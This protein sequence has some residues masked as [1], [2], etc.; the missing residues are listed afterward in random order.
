MLKLILIGS[1]GLIFI[2]ALIIIIRNKPDLWFWIFLNLYFDPGGYVLEYL[3]GSLLGPLSITD[4]FITGMVICLIS[5]HT[6]WKVIIQDQFLKK[7]IFLLFLFV[8]YYFIVYG[9]VVPFFNDDFNY[10]TFLMKNRVYPYGFIILI[11][12]YVFTLR[13]IS[14]FYSS[15]LFVGT[16]CLTL[17]FITL[18]TGIELIPIWEFARNPGEEAIRISM[19]SYGIFYLLFPLS[20]IV[21]LLSRRMSL[22]FKYK[23]WLYYSGII[24]LITLLITLTKRLQIDIIGTILIITLIIS[25]IF[26]SGS[27]SSILKIIIPAMLVILI[28]Y[29]T[30]PKYGGYIVEI[31][32]DTFLLIATGRDS[33]GE[34]D[35]RV[36]GT[37]DY[38]LVKEYISNNL[39]FG[40]GY[41]NLIWTG[42]GTRTTPRGDTFA[43]VMD[44]AGEV[45]IYFMFFSFGITGA[46]LISLLYF[47][48]V[49]L[50]IKLLKL[51]R[52]TFMNY[53]QE[54]II[55]MFS[56]Y[57]LLTI[58]TKFTINLYALS[59]DFLPSQIAPTAILLG[60]GFALY[61]KLS[62]NLNSE[63]ESL[64][65]G[66]NLII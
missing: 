36:T 33:K 31:G 23:Y 6:N 45:P 49:Q 9:A 20:L 38:D 64:N 56:I 60:I 43:R 13:S 28:L 10:N 54:P 11:A 26:K 41:T 21:Y 8:A 12:V 32:E 35:Q 14:Y 65:N 7:F 1:V 44:A 2:F 5:T 53:L 40:T 19:L 18:I 61:R 59:V 17:Y 42:P 46:V 30:F 27:L 48:M 15:T 66:Q 50:F 58:V 29:F 39:F 3:G 22:D 34:S 63:P 52:L 55:I 47:M 57:I 37:G 4:V 25:Y 51:L 16:I 62:L 24:M